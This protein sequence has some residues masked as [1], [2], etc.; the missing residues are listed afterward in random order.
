MKL[1][2]TKGT[3]ADGKRLEPSDKPQDVSDKAG[4]TL[5]AMRIAELPNTAKKED[6]AKGITSESG[7]KDGATKEAK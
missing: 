1:I 4:R 2:I 6:K 7:L 3:I 5:L